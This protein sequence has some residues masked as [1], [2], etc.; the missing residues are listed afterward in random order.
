M[1]SDLVTGVARKELVCELRHSNSG[2]S[3]T[4]IPNH[5]TDCLNKSPVQTVPI[6]LIFPL[7]SPFPQLRK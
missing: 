2:T 3:P 1:L 6:F 4:P 5:W 7:R